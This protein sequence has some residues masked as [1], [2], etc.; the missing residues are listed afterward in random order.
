MED[1]IDAD[2]THT[3]RVCKDSEIGNLGAHHNFY[4][5]SDTL[6]LGDLFNNFLNMCLVIYG[7]DPD[8]FVYTE[9]IAWKA[10]TMKAKAKSDHLTDIHML[11]ITERAIT[12]GICHA[13]HRYGKAHKYMEDYDKCKES[14]CCNYWNENNLYGVA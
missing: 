12:G 11:L 7:A 3:K 9:R 5:Q 8:R 14:L 4:A 2:Y 6:L 13:I 10:P 1:I